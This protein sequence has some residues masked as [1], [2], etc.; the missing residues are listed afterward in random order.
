MHSWCLSR[1]TCSSRQARRVQLY[2]SLAKF[3]TIFFIPTNNYM[4]V[5]A[6]HCRFAFVRSISRCD[7]ISLTMS[8]STTSAGSGGG[9]GGG[10]AAA[11]ASSFSELATNYWTNGWV[12]A[13]GLFSDDEVDQLAREAADGAQSPCVDDRCP[14]FRRLVLDPRVVN[15]VK[16]ILA[17]R[18]G[19]GSSRVADEL[20]EPLLVAEQCAVSSSRFRQDNAVA[21]SAVTAPGAGITAWLALGEGETSFEYVSSSH[22][23]L[24][25][26]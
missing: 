11:A 14:S 2:T 6:H 4:L 8:A 24:I 9:G 26:I 7:N 25:H 3:E 19:G 5:A 16:V 10:A 23:S 17:K 1:A 22:L 20:P 18:S 12:V 15:R 21:L 13:E